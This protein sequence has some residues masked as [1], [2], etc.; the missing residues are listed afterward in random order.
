MTTTMKYDS[1]KPKVHFQNLD[2]AEW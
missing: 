2:P 1:P